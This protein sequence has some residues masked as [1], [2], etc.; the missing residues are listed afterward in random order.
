MEEIN[1]F[2]KLVDDNNAKYALKIFQEESITIEDNLAN[3]FFI[4]E[5]KKNS[6]IIVLSV[7]LCG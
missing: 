5:V 4:G 2:Y 7:Y 6:G 1:I 3:V